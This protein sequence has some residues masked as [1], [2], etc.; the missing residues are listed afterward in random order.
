MTKRFP[1][2]CQRDSRWASARLLPSTLT[3]GRYGCTSTCVCMVASYFKCFV[4]PENAVNTRNFYTKDGLIL[5]NKLN[6]PNFKPLQR[7]YSQ[8]DKLIEEALKNPDKHVILNVASGSHWVLPTSKT[9]WGNDYK[10]IDPW[11]G[12][13]CNAKGRYKNINGGEIFVRK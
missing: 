8:D 10:I 11:D 12:S 7:F 5:W 9:L 1:Q 3:I 6:W 4:T 13:I 2:L